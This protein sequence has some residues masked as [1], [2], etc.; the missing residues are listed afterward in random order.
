M[1]AHGLRDSKVTWKIF[2]DTSALF[3]LISKR[4][5]PTKWFDKFLNEP[6]TLC[7]TEAVKKE[8]ENIA[9]T[10]TGKT[11]LRAQLATTFLKNFRVVSTH[12]NVAD[13]SIVEASIETPNGL[14]FT[15][16]KALRHRLKSLGIGVF[17][18][19]RDGRIIFSN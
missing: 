2:V 5:D 12:T 18:F 19:S 14:A 15:D 9:S 10:G 3:H 17:L 13:N 7:V 4:N 6:Y 8:I 16:D 11:K 1:A